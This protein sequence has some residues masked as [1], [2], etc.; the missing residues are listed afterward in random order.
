MTLW[1]LLE[2]ICFVTPISGALAGAR[3]SKAG[4]GGYALGIGVGLALGF[5]FA[6]T[7]W[8]AGRAFVART[9]NKPDSARESYAR[10]LY[11]GAILWIA[12]GLVVGEWASSAAMRLVF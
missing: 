8:N 1:H 4:F 6:W 5:C 12:F 10:L 2:A 9:K 7:M 11:F 3:L